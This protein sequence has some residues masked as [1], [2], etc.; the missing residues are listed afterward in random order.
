MLKL[1]Y[2]VRP[3]RISKFASIITQTL[4]SFND[5]EPISS[6]R[7][8]MRQK[9]A[10]EKIANLFVIDGF[11]DSIQLPENSLDM[12]FTSNA[13]G[14]NIEKELQEIERVVKPYGQ[15]CHIML[16]ER[17]PTKNPLHD[18]LVSRNWKYS[19]IQSRDENC[20]KAKYM[21]TIT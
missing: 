14:W 8:F 4:Y 3:D 21:K 7:T 5:I 13:I 16:I 1:L 11:L 10:R 12:L 20:I 2:G 6:F 9:A 19:L 15:A 18:T 17:N